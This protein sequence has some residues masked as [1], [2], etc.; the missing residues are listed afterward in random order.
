LVVTISDPRSCS[1]ERTW[2][3]SSAA[4]SGNVRWPSSSRQTSPVRA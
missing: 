1:S 2:K 4:L 3:T